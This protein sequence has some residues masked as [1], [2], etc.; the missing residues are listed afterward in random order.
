MKYCFA[1]TALLFALASQAQ[2][3]LPTIQSLDSGWNAIATDGVCSA[4]TPF[5]FYARDSAASDDLLVFFNGGGA[6]WFGQACDLNVQ[7]NIHSPFADM[8]EN[9]PAFSKGI[10]D[11][12]NQNNPFIS[13][14]MV[15]IP[16]CTGD[17]HI[18][19][20][21]KSYEY[22]DG[23]GE[24]ANVVAHHN[25][26]ENSTRV[27]DW[28]YKNYDAPSRIVVSGSS[29]GAI[30]SSFYSGLIAEQYQETPVILI[31][32]AAG[33]YGSPLMS[34]THNAWNTAAV[35]PVWSEY[36][37]ETN[38]SISF[39]D[40]YI[41]S[42]NHNPN[43]TIAQYNA[44]EDATQK[45]FTQLIGDAP[46]SFS[47][48]QRILNN[49]LEIESSV[50]EFYSYT[51]GGPV[52]MIMQADIFYG[53]KVEEVKFADWV[54]RLVRGQSVEDVSCVNEADGCSSSPSI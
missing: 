3:D 22:T 44:A 54:H 48:P 35:L 5:Q 32:D 24:T 31:A 21:E 19:A 26:Y 17:V 38:D 7:P 10:F 12:E 53:Y 29:A 42:A 1:L 13:F 28:M 34:K 8:D 4:G 52:H 45:I 6:C 40:F 33:G 16:Y 47:L 15:F 49:Y 36:A 43:L 25:G 46:G 11:F 50:N 39:E 18:G 20:G 2:T 41:A 51:A 27:L 37:G 14:D 9:N 23:S 30:G